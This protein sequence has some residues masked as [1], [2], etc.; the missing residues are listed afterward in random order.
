[1]RDNGWAFGGNNPA[2][3]TFVLAKATKM[4]AIA[5]FNGQLRTDHRL[6]SFKV[7][8][9]ANNQWGIL[10]GLSIREDADAQIGNDG[11]ITLDS[12]IQVIHLDFNLIPNAKKIHLVVFDTD[13]ANNNLV[14]NEIVPKFFKSK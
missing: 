10:T 14:L 6:I 11:T 12:G 5:L 13:A 1:M 8:V 9:K 4:N 3:A 7:T 2:S